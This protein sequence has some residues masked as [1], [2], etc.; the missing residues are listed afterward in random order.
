MTGRC[1]TIIF[2]L[3]LGV[4]P[5]RAQVS[6]EEHAKH[7]PPQGAGAPS[8][9]QPATGSQPPGGMMEGMQEMMKGMGGTPPKQIYP[10][11]MELPSLPPEKRDELQKTAHE[12]MQSGSAL[13]AQGFDALVKAAPTTDY[14]A[15]Q[16]ALGSI[17]EGLARFDSGLAAHRALSEGRDPRAIALNWFKAQMNLPGPPAPSEVRTVLRLSVAH[18]SLMAVLI[19]FAV[20][21]IAMYFL[22]MRRAATLLQRL[23]E[24][25]PRPLGRL[26]PHRPR[27]CRDGRD[28]DVPP[29]GPRGRPHPVHLHR[30]TVS[31]AHHRQGWQDGQTLLHHRVFP[32]P[33]GLRRTHDQTRGSGLR[34]PLPL[35]PGPRG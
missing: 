13:M 17:R 6:P 8:G 11:L 18:F 22:K 3:V 19:A 1:L 28:Q 25:P 27:L 10:S 20:A 35:R 32:D 24:A 12:R 9:S 30:G 23:T 34:L 14:K 33:A 21:M 5:L 2:A 29:R 15:M 26:A 16:D 31:Y 7:H 4:Q